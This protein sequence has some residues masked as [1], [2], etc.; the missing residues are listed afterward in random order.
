[1]NRKTHLTLTTVCLLAIA[2]LLAGRASR[3]GAYVSLI[4]FRATPQ[5]NGSILVRWETAVELNTL[6]FELFRT[7][8]DSPAPWDGSP[9]AIKPATGDG[10][11]GAVYTYDDTDV[12]PAVTYYYWLQERMIEGSIGGRFGPVRAGDMP[13]TAGVRYL[14]LMLRS[15]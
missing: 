9:I 7:K 4:D 14:P 3:V 8:T 15:K 11:T 1:M 6:S 12:T 2:S 13:P 10:V 5:P